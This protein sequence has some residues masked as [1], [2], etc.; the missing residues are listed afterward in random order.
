MIKIIVIDDEQKAVQSL[1]TILNEYCEDIEICGTANSALEG[2]ILINQKRPDLLFLDIEMPNGSG[3]DLL[4][5]ISARTFK[6]VFTTA[7]NH[8]AIKAIKYSAIDYLL[9]PIDIDEVIAVVYKVQTKAENPEHFQNQYEN[10]LSNL[11]EPE[12]KRVLLPTNEG[13][14]FFYISDIIRIEADGSYSKIFLIKNKILHISK[15]IKEIETLI[16]D[17]RFFR[18]HNSFLIN[19]DFIA[20]FLNKD[21]GCIEMTDQA[22]IPLSRRKKIEFFEKFKI[23]NK[24]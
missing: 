1:C 6:V 12:R 17:D 7:F 9:K 15:N 21:G 14:V 16:C 3:F 23:T 11:K 19:T 5:M 4:D 13:I 24:E 18:P 8:Y 2:L 10:F 22:E 20:K